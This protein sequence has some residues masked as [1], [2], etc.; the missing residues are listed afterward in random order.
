M[1]AT[2]IAEVS[3][4][5]RAVSAQA[6]KLGKA[7]AE[8]LERRPGPEQWSAA[9]C[10]THLAISAERYEP[11][12]REAYTAA[13]RQG[14]GGHEPYRMDFIGRLLNWTLEPGR[15]RFGAPPTFQPVN[16]GSA[17]ESLARFLKSQDMVLSFI[18]E[19]AP[20]PLDRMTIA[21]P[22]VTTM[23]FSVWSSF[24]ILATHGRRH[25]R[26]AEIAS[27]LR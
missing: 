27:G 6:E 24:V 15:F 14:V 11:V 7:K 5:L 10:L 23:R 9:E 13:K 25:L 18:A 21:S 1:P 26:Q 4:A 16:C 3:D 8:Q 22:A 19:G 20:L 2:R 17:A 12:W